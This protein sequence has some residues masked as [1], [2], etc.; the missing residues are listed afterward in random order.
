MG[1]GA[2]EAH[3]YG[4]RAMTKTYELTPEEADI[5]D[6]YRA[7]MKFYAENPDDYRSK[8]HRELKELNEKRPR[9]W[10]SS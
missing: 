10:V 5:I 8:L 7:N 9:L 3:C 6:V 4:E 2:E 1:L